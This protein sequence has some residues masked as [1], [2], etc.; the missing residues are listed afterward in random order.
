[1][2]PT[3]DNGGYRKFGYKTK[4][5][6]VHIGTDFNAQLNSY[7]FAGYDGT[8]IFSD[9]VNGFGGRNPDRKGGVIII[10]HKI[11]DKSYITL[12]GHIRKFHAKGV[13]VNEGDPIGL[14]D[15][16][17]DGENNIPH[18]HYGIHLG[19]FIPEYPWG[20][21]LPEKVKGWVDPISFENGGMI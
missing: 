9:Q 8:I 17:F 7:V 13:I 19:A 1:M 21:V 3:T 10:E 16:Y 18:L 2:L 11:N 15:N 5:G 14:V 6:L 12:Y 20:Y 4:S